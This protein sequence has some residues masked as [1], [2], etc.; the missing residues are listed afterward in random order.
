VLEAAAQTQLKDALAAIDREIGST[1]SN[2]ATLSFVLSE[3][4]ISHT[5]TGRNNADLDTSS[6][7]S[8]SG[9]ELSAKFAFIDL[10]YSQ[11]KKL[12]EDGIISFMGYVEEVAVWMQLADVR[13]VDGEAS[14]DGDEVPLEDDE[15]Y[16]EMV[17]GILPVRT[18]NGWVS[19][20][21]CGRTRMK[22]WIWIGSE[23]ESRIIDEDTE[24]HLPQMVFRKNSLLALVW[25]GGMRIRFGI[26]IGMC[27]GF[28]L[29]Y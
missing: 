5:A 15:E 13:S 27:L 4:D 24:L 20:L 21:L 3:I 11:A 22:A 1:S 19:R 10:L 28:E 12:T 6:G 7:T 18:K 8:I 9:A 26:G 25:I 16:V 17:A 23:E 2:L 14:A 29:S